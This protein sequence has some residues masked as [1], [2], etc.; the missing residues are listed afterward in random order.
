[1]K[2]E[3]FA[4]WARIYVDQFKCYK[5]I[6]STNTGLQ[7]LQAVMHADLGGLEVTAGRLYYI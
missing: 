6:L 2:P 7:F 5:Y 1:M 3:A 4:S